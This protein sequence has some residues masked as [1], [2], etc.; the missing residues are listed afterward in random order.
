MRGLD[1]NR[2]DQTRVN[3]SSINNAGTAGL[4]TRKRSVRHTGIRAI[5]AE[6]ITILLYHVSVI[7]KPNEIA[8]GK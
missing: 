1:K 7:T 2:L 3:G 6:R 4:K 8:L 5:N